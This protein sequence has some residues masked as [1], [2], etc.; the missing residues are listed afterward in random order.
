MA[1]N[2][3]LPTISIVTP[4]YNQGRFIEETIRSVLDQN[5]PKLEYII[6][7]GGST[8]GSVEIIK[9]YAD[10]LTY[11]VSE[12]D[13]GQ[14]DAI[15]KGFAKSTGEIMAWLNSDDKYLPWTLNT[16]GRIFAS[17]P[18]IQWLTSQYHL[19]W[20]EAGEL[21]EAIYV[22]FHTR[23]WF[24]RGWTLQK[25]KGFKGWIQQEST[26]WRR[27]L[28]E[29][30][31]GYVD[32][33]LYYAGDFELWARFFQYADL[34]TT[35]IPL[36]G[37]RRQSQ[38]KTVHEK[39]YAEADPILAKYRDQTIHHPWLV[40]LLQKVLDLTGR[41]GERFGSRA[42]FVTYDRYTDTWFYEHSHSI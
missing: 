33:S 37:W 6:I 12:P 15:N 25:N 10:R 11:W 17:V 36:A 16:V 20:N 23:T 2:W 26:F 34:A 19:V 27:E 9:K 41:G 42:P 31:G 8:D 4:S 22:P 21:V 1:G 13:K 28:W 35:R 3:Q 32:A 29:K 38:Q 30:A 14:Y 40:W 7:D 24:Y 5:Y 18:Q 39:Y